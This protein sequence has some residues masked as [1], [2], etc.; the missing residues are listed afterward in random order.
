MTTH[1]RSTV[2]KSSVRCADGSATFITV[3]SS[4]TINS[5]VAITPKTSQ[6][7]F[8]RTGTCPTPCAASFADM[9]ISQG[10]PLD[11]RREA[12]VISGSVRGSRIDSLVTEGSLSV[13]LSHCGSGRTSGAHPGKPQL[14]WKSRSS[15][16]SAHDGQLR[17]NA[18]A[19]VEYAH[20]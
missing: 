6:G 2:V 4:T 3:R 9:E 14:E 17:A 8:A 10:S 15:R 1:C 18:I 11:G 5:A 19:W 7:G 12:P 16:E 13:T 20:T